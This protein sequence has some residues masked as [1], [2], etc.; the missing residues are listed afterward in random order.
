MNEKPNDVAGRLPWWKRPER[1]LMALV[2]LLTLTMLAFFLAGFA[3]GNNRLH[4]YGLYF[5]AALVVVASTPLVAHGF[6]VTIEKLS[7]RRRG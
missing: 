5:F 2:I 3:L 7:G 4:R 1:V 6:G